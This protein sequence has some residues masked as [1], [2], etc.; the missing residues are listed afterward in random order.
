MVARLHY[1]GILATDFLN[2]PTSRWPAA[3]SRLS[4]GAAAVPNTN[5]PLPIQCPKCDH[6]G[7]KL[8][9][10]S[11]TVMTLTCASCAHTWATRLDWLPADIQ[12]KVRAITL[13]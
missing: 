7:S 3:S 8:V 9:V 10:K 6:N 5:D 13:H 12:E 1:T 11:L 4:L 2:L